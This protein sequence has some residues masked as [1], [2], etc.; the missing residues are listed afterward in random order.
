MENM[1]PITIGNTY[2]VIRKIGSGGGGVVYLAEHLRLNKS[3][4]LK[5]D[6]RTLSAKPDVLRR[7]VDSLKN[8]SHT[9]IPQ[10]YDF[11]V[12]DGTVYTVMDY[13][14]GES[15]DKPLKRGEQFTQSQV[16]KWAC[17]LLDALVYL[18]SRPPHGILHADL[19]PSNVMLTPQGDVRLI[20]FN[21]ALALGEEGAVAV[22]R[23][24]GYASP[25]HYGVSYSSNNT[26]DEI[27]TDV[28]TNYS[29][30]VV[31]DVK[32]IFENKQELDLQGSTTSKKTIMLD[33]RS[34]IYSLGATLYH[35]I[36]GVR[37]AQDA[38]EVK[39]I[40]TNGYSLA[41]IKIIEKAMNSNPNLRYQ[42][43]EEMLN[44]FRHLRENDP[45]TK[46]YKRKVIL[47][48]IIFIM[49]FLFGG[50]TTFVG[51]KQMEQ[52]QNMYVLSEY[53]GNAL[54]E[55][56]VDM[57]IDYALQA[58]PQKRDIFTPPQT[59]EAQ[60]ALTD[61][62]NV[63]DLSDGFKNSKTV[64]LPSAPLFMEISPNGK[65]AA[66]IYAYSVA[67]FDTN[68]AEILFNFLVENSA[69]AE[70]KYID[71]NRIAFA[72]EG[73]IK[74]YDIEK[75]KELW[76][77]KPAT[78]I[79]VSS[80]HKILASIYK[81]ENFA[82][83]YDVESG[84]IIEEIDFQDK[85]QRVAINDSFANP[86]DNLFVL[87]KEGTLLGVSFADGSLWVY[88]LINSEGDLELFDKTSGYIHFDGGFFEQ[89][90]AF[91]A[92]NTL[93]S[94]FAIID[95]LKMEQTGGFESEKPFGVQSDESGIYVQTENILVQIHPVTGEQRALVNTVENIFEFDVSE[96]YT[97]LSTDINYLFFDQYANL[98]SKIEKKN[99]NNF[100]QIAGGKSIMGGLDDPNI[101]IMK[102]E[103]YSESE[104]FSY[105][106]SYIHNEVRLSKD[107]ETVMLFSFDQFRL[108]NA[109]G[110]LIAEKSIPNPEHVYDQQYIRD[111][112]GSRLEVIYNDGTICAYSAKDG[113]LLYEETGKKPD[114]TLFEE[115]FTDTLR[116]ESPLHGVPKAYDMKTGKFISDL[117]KDAYLTYVTQVDDYIITE[118]ITADNFRYGLLLNSKCE[119]LAYL[120]YLCDIMEGKLIFDYPTGN[121]RE[122][123][124][125]HINE[126]IELTR[127]Q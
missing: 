16:I 120:P 66:V 39:P 89:Y 55:G 93:G 73:G 108:Y 8:L 84:N 38:T 70:V 45:R 48:A 27:I 52:M 35:I 127:K 28:E 83:I 42:S 56:D 125:Y 101:Q 23:S 46:R 29:H 112:N 18:H 10:V 96:K 59:A 71:E 5:A 85:Y 79:T 95:T 12:E 61:A 92:T 76:T 68:T 34:D 97:L 20:D 123:R 30:N 58:L 90:F 25:E 2:K 78:S 111:S 80:N 65:T 40:S 36:T 98:I 118:Y 116:I 74:V 3:V 110:S 33:V 72:G 57:A 109:N 122:S 64:K 49:L 69:L 6:K 7:E 100:I 114:L 67:V 47:T 119:K 24:F 31:T 115:F 104:I 26:K 77:G 91:S 21:I 11:I 63:Y 15:F 88:D 17:Q 117:E 32:T 37:P 22:G 86:N 121:L 19:K 50:F 106:P 102:L 54:K 82:T 75:N 51:L 1:I 124:I 99:N 60:K 94:V 113:S 62:L 53:S 126:L 4:V 87:N 41:V 44:D 105:D 81:D 103:N 43:A 9:N 14:D 107:K 13:I